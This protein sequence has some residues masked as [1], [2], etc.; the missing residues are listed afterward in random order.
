M[1]RTSET[2]SDSYRVFIVYPDKVLREEVL[3][4]LV[5]N[6]YE[7]YEVDSHQKLSSLVAVAPSIVYANVDLGPNE[8][9]WKSLLEKLTARHKPPQLRAG[10][11]S[12]DQE[13]VQRW[14]QSE[15]ELQA[16]CVP[17]QS[18]VTSTLMAKLLQRFAAKG[19]RKFVRAAT[20]SRFPVKFNM[21]VGETVHTGTIQDISA[22]GMTCRFEADPKLQRNSYLSHVLITAKDLKCTASGTV[23]GAPQSDPGLYLIMFDMSVSSTEEDK[24]YSIVRGSLQASL[25]DELAGLSE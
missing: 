20:S 7:A 25:A 4:L 6:E 1:A 23:V 2:Q 12:A 21:K 5:R 24:L 13:T 16:G 17:I 15:T 3:P 11:L 19:R 22:A 14:K 9:T 10:I 8:A 18:G